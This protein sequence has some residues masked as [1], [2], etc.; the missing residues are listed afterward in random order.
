MINQAGNPLKRYLFI[1]AL[2]LAVCLSACNSL[3]ADADKVTELSLKQVMPQIPPAAKVGSRPL[4]K[5]AGVHPRIL[6]PAGGLAELRKRAKTTHARFVPGIKKMADEIMEKGPS[7]EPT[8]TESVMR[9]EMRKP[10]QLAWAYIATGDTKYRDAAI[11]YTMVA[12]A[13]PKWDIDVDLA[14]SHGMVAISQVYDWFYD[15]LTADQRKTIVEKIRYQGNLLNSPFVLKKV[16]GGT[17]WTR[18]YLQNHGMENSAGL[19]AGGAVFYHEIPEA[20]QWLENAEAHFDKVFS[21]M[22]DDGST[23][24]GMNYWG[25]SAE[26]LLLYADMAKQITGRDFFATSGHLK[27]LGKFLIG[28]TTPWLRNQDHVFPYG[29]PSLG[30]GT[31]GPYH[32][33]YKSAAISRHPQTQDMGDQTWEADFVSW[34]PFKPYVLLWYDPT[35]EAKSFRTSDT[36]NVFPEHGLV[37]VRDSWDENATAIWFK[38]GPFQGKAASKIFKKSV[39]SA[40]ARA[41]QM[42]FQIVTRGQ[43]MTAYGNWKSEHFSFPMFRGVDQYGGSRQRGL[44]GREIFKM[45]EVEPSLKRVTTSEGFDYIAGDAGKIYRAD[46]GVKSFRRHIV[47]LKPDDIL[48][49]DDISL[50]GGKSDRPDVDWRLQA[51]AQPRKIAAN[52]F[53]IEVEN[54]AM[55]VIQCLPGDFKM[56]ATGEIDNDGYAVP[57]QL[58]TIYR[59]NIESTEPVTDTVVVTYLRCRD[60]TDTP[61]TTPEVSLDGRTVTAKVITAGGSK[62]VEVNLGNFTCKVTESTE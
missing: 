50:A 26:H 53:V 2:T 60:K 8:Q 40:H 32:T 37:T 31:H 59:L 29:A 49:I 43:R 28:M 45:V 3:F 56:S 24:E 20:R 21:I 39:A 25:Y 13:Y 9:R 47:F 41:D 6:I 55:D 52:H 46:A 10:G 14:A 33:M 22:P 19:F 4:D 7:I 11:E 58:M 38:C 44:N 57:K 12:C 51:L 61:P 54:A 17:W 18:E 30:T 34:S 36:A 16:K 23:M 48:I 5:M 27:N 15:D 1:T 35:L 42:S 62:L